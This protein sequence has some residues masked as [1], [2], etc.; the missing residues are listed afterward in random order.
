MKLRSTIA[1]SQIVGDRSQVITERFKASLVEVSGFAQ[2]DKHV[3]DHFKKE[4][5][6]LTE[7][8]FTVLENSVKREE[9]SYD[10]EMTADLYYEISRGYVASPD[11][12]ATWLENLAAF[13]E[14]VSYIF[15][16]MCV[17]VTLF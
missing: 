11:L 10:P 4:V 2:N 9:Y 12:R 16:I 7:R 5:I 15:I 1:V 17:C 6:D 14:A 13:H 8:L 3:P